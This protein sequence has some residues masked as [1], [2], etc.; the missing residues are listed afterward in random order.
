MDEKIFESIFI[1]IYFDHKVVTC[2]TIY[3]S[4]KKDTKSLN[5]FFEY[6]NFVFNKLKHNKNVYIMG[7]TNINLIDQKDPGTEILTDTM[8]NSNLFPLINH[9]TRLSNN[10]AYLDKYNLCQYNKWHI[11]G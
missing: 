6:L 11:S 4:P 5:K 7:D 2:G 3:R 1:D 8:F 9:P 10:C